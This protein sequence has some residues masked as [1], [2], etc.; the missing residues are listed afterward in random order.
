MLTRRLTSTIVAVAALFFGATSAMAQGTTTGAIGGLVTD[1]E[2]RPAPNARI[3]ITNPST[4]FLVR[5][6]TRDNGRYFIQS[7]EV[8]GPYTVT[9]RR[10][11]FEPVTR[12]NVIV[13]LGQTTPVDVQLTAQA[14]Q[15]NSVQVLATAEF[16]SSKT[17]VGT[18]VSDSII[19]RLPTLN[20][21]VMDLVKLSPHVAT[22]T[23]GGPSAAG[24][25]PIQ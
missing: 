5:G 19:R 22:Q 11:G 24:V 14:V 3:E 10:I 15:L 17:G 18:S 7:L 12:S 23:T 20:R 2:G 1:A 4:G 16:S 25:Q 8:G 21:D 13:Q 9:A 6:L